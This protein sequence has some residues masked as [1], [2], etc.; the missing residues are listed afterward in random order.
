MASTPP[1]KVAPTNDLQRIEAKL[2]HLIVVVETR[3]ALVE[4]FDNRL[5]A[6]TTLER[7]LA[8]TALKLAAA[9]VLT[10]GYAGAIAGA[11]AGGV[12]AFLLSTVAGAH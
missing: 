10:S 9:K 3:K 4:G 8:S 1:A 12:V 6:A 2:D 11:I 7:G 5:A